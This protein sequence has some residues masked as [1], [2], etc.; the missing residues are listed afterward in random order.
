MRVMIKLA[1]NNTSLFVPGVWSSPINWSCRSD[2]EIFLTGQCHSSKNR[3][4]K[5]VCEMG[6][7][8]HAERL[9][10]SRNFP[11]LHRNEEISN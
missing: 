11:S 10:Y 3:E 7:T 5:T 9:E 8:G 4:N 2:I 1:F 6:Q